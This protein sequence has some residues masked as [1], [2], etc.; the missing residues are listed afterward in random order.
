MAVPKRQFDSGSEIA[1]ALVIAVPPV[2][3]VVAAAERA[4][5]GLTWVRRRL[6]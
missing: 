2:G 6:E 4:V 1:I 5:D 3:L